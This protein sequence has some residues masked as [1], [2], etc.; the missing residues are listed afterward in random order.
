MSDGGKAEAG[1]MERLSP[2]SVWS[3]T[4]PKQSAAPGARC[5]RM[6][7]PVEGSAGAFHFKPALWFLVV[8]ALRLCV[9]VH[10]TPTR[11]S[12]QRC[13]M[14]TANSAVRL[15]DPQQNIFHILF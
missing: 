2:G 4:N 13:A 5:R 12:R 3:E 14:L 6:P 10:T 11:A 7:Q 9:Y 1:G 8:E 15:F